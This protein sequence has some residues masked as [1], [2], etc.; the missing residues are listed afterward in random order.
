[1][2]ITI[3]GPPGSGKTTVAQLLSQNLG[4][5][6]ITGGTIFRNYAKERNIP[7]SEMGKRAEIDSEFDKELDSYLLSILKSRDNV[8]VESRLSGWLCY[9]NNI[10]AFKIY[11]TADEIIR[12]N[13]IRLSLH[14]RKEEESENLAETILERE[15]SERK[16]YIKYYNIDFKD[17]SIYDLVIDSSNMDPAKV[18]GVIIDGL[19]IWKRSERKNY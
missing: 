8:I 14:E 1:M 2:K 7:L 12:L 17:L 6:L 13:R 11:L 18:V 9:L 3:S 16:R 10:D 19:D 15:K 5:E 4:Y